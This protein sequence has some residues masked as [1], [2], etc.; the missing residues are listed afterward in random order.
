MLIPH[1]TTIMWQ[2]SIDKHA[3]MGALGFRQE[4]C[5]TLLKLNT[6]EGSFEKADSC[7]GDKFANCGPSYRTGNNTISVCILLQPC[8]ASA[9]STVCQVSQ[10]ES[11]PPV[12]SNRPTNFGL[13]RVPWSSPRPSSS[14]LAASIQALS[15]LPKGPSRRHPIL[16]PRYQPTNLGPL[17]DP[18][19][20][21]WFNFNPSELWSGDN[22]ACSGNLQETCPFVSPEGLQT[23]APPPEPK[24][25]HWLD[26]CLS[27][28]QI[29]SNPTLPRDPH[30]D[31]VRAYPEARWSHIHYHT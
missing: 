4:S 1:T 16:C 3:F 17:G 7:P 10:E 13:S 14:T 27:Q 28:T 23:T 12:S 29:S 15:C 6:K 2:S 20:V 21:L 18:E 9:A 22:P 25:I 24:V 31:P 5:K 30:S 19:A 8:I 11:H 26:F